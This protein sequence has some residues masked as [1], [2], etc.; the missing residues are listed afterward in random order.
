M[1]QTRVILSYLYSR[2]L[3]RRRNQDTI[4]VAFEYELNLRIAANERS[5]TR[6]LELTKQVVGPQQCSPWSKETT[7]RP[8]QG[9]ST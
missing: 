9:S 6:Q 3:V 2:S 1:R 5:N 8:L 4:G 7:V